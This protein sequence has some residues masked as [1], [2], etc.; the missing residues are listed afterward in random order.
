MSE[1]FCLRHPVAVNA[2]II[3]RG[4]FSCTEMLRMCVLYVSVWSK[5]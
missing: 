5:E 4:L 2:F 3:C 1:S